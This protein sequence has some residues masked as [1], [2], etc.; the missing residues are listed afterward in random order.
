MKYND[1]KDL[2]VDELRKKERELRGELFNSKMKNSLGQLA[3]PISI[4]AAR[5]NVAR[6]KTAQSQ[7]LAK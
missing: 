4:R 7:K 1:V 3:S 6:L 5:R 2:T